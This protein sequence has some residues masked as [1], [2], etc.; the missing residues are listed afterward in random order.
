MWAADAK[1]NHQLDGV[2]SP[3]QAAGLIAAVGYYE[4]PSDDDLLTSMRELRP[5]TRTTRTAGV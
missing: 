4:D 3:Y 5:A 2:V 1:I